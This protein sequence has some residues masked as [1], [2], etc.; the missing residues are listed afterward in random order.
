M[1]QFRI[2]TEH[3]WCSSRLCFMKTKTS[4]GATMSVT[5][6]VPSSTPTS[7]AA[8]LFVWR[9]GHGSCMRGPTTWATSTF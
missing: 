2:P 7:A 1:Y 4:K 3:Q 8:T 5:V 9:V 6:T